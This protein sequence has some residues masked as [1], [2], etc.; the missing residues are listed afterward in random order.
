MLLAIFGNKPGFGSIGPVY[1][2]ISLVLML[3]ALPCNL[4]CVWS[5]PGRKLRVLTGLVTHSRELWLNLGITAWIGVV[6]FVA[7][8]TLGFIGNLPG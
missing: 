7:D 2:T 8:L 5:I 4:V 6:S 3:F 1:L